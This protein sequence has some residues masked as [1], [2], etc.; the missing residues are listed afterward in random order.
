MCIRDSL[1]IPLPC[2]KEMLGAMATI[3]LGKISLSGQ[4]LYEKLRQ[5]F[6]IEVPVIPWTGEQTLVRISA[7][8]YNYI[9]QYDYLADVLL[10]F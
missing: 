1:D 3:P 2:P 4:D 6:S 5:D 10:G 8:F 9:E 7:Q